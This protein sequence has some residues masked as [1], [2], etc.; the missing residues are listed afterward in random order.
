VISI[1]GLVPKVIRNGQMR[2]HNDASLH[3]RFCRNCCTY[4]W[5]T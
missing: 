3:F 4:L 1:R 2:T 5:F